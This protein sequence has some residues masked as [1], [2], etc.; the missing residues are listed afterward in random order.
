M[1]NRWLF[2]LITLVAG[3]AR[4]GAQEGEEAY[5]KG[6]YKT[7]LQE[8]KKT[9]KDPSTMAWI[10]FMYLEGNGV[11]KDL[12]IAASWIEKAANGG[13]DWAQFKFGMLLSDGIG[14]KKN[15]SN[16]FEWLQKA[17]DAGNTDAIA[18]LG[19][20]YKYGRGTPASPEKALELFRLGAE[21]G[22]VAAQYALGYELYKGE[23]VPVD[24]PKAREL[25]QV[26]FDKT[27]DNGAAFYLGYMYDEGLGGSKDYA[28]AFRFYKVAADAGSNAAQNNLA[29]M[30]RNGRG[31]TPNT[32]E[33]IYWYRK[34]AASG[35][36]KA[37]ENLVSLQKSIE[38]QQQR[39]ARMV[40]ER[41][42]AQ[43]AKRHP[44][45]MLCNSGSGTM[46]EYSGYVVMGKPYYI[47]NKGTTKISAYVE[48]SSPPKLSLRVA[49]LE[50][51]YPNGKTVN[52]DNLDSDWGQLAPNRVFWS[53]EN[54]WNQCY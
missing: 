22:D 27:S 10:G 44:G 9:P 4:A 15:E 2:T 3:L 46:K 19:R 38:E 40:A 53:D 35:N 47:D 28:K 42:R 25:L 52:M 5:K 30:Y 31:V 49:R 43:A 1:V 41:E 16:A 12:K 23:I 18:P 20:M 54:L 34:A 7:A 17:F 48:N 21:K 14:I 36:T 37:R 50:F 11:K 39:E 8:F 51:I 6:D 26:V 24:Y 29:S 13:D 32:D 45:T 33:A